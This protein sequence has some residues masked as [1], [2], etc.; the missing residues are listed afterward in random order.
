MSLWEQL[1]LDTLESSVVQVTAC[2]PRSHDRTI[3]YPATW[4]RGETP[5]GRTF[6]KAQTRR[7]SS[8]QGSLS[9]ESLDCL[10]FCESSNECIH[11]LTL[12][13]ASR[14]RFFSLA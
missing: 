8:D 7:S 2:G 3:A 11:I 5:M 1:G 10:V 12:R 13:R 14:R 4:L 9:L 6:R